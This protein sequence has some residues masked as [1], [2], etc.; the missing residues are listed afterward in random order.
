MG[1]KNAPPEVR[2]HRHYTPVESGC[3]LWTGALDRKGYGQM[4]VGGKT[5]SATHFSLFMD[6][7]PRPHKNACALH[8]CDTPACVNPDHLWWGSHK[9]NSQDM[10]AKG[11]NNAV[12]LPKAVAAQ[13][14]KALARTTCKRGHPVSSAKIYNGCRQ[15]GECRNLLRREQRAALRADGWRVGI[16]RSLDDAIDYCREWGML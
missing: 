14:A 11:R 1:A 8:R 16:A 13:A 2:F 15:C 3:W 5:T 9:E 6:G 4:N 7:R 12:G 10:A